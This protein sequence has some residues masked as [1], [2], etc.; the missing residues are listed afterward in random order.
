MK[1]RVAL[2][3]ISVVMIMSTCTACSE[4]KQAVSE[5]DI[6]QVRNICNLATL[7]CYYHN[8]AKSVKEAGSGLWHIGEKDRTFWV[9]YTGTARLGIDMS[10]VSMKVDGENV[11]VFIPEAEV[12]SV[13][14]DA[15]SLTEDSYIESQDSWLNHNKISADNQTEAINQAQENMEN[16]V[17][18]NSSLLL[19]AQN[20]AKAL[21]ENYIRQLGEAAG[22]E[23]KIEWI[24]DEIVEQ[25]SKQET[26]N[27]ESTAINK[28]E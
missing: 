21:I 23:Y 1:R 5:P 2:I 27:E 11:S 26:V 8:V 18:G 19:T 28:S 3:I 22:I 16:E 10:K 13:K 4:K 20:R 6:T 24:Y 17:R 12:L 15:D 9:E 14:I 7:E 25:S